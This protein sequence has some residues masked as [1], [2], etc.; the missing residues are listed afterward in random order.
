MSIASTNPYMLRT[1][2][3]TTGIRLL[4]IRLGFVRA[5][6]EIPTALL[7]VPKAVPTAA[8]EGEEQR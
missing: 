4:M 3:I 5:I 2:D 1:P 8:R 7:A 6:T